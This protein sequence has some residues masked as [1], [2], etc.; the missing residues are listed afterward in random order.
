MIAYNSL[1]FARPT[2]VF[3]SAGELQEY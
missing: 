2:V 1:T 3:N